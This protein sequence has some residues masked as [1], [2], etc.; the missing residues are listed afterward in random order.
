MSLC[1]I[2]QCLDRIASA[3]T[4]SP[5]VIYRHRGMVTRLGCVFA[6]TLATKQ[7]LAAGQLDPIGIYHSGMDR[8]AIKAEL[9]AALPK[10]ASD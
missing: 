1:T 3:P 8:E 9:V 5:L 10:P 6:D 2:T 7:A 4:N